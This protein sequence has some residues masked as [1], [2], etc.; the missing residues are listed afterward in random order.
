[1][2]FSEIEGK[3]K[4]K[5]LCVFVHDVKSQCYTYI[6]GKNLGFVKSKIIQVDVSF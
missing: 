6:Q 4:K 5:Y 1:M 2:K 3:K